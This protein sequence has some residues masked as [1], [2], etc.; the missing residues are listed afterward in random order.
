MS[1]SAGKVVL[2]TGASSGL[3]AATAE[4]CVAAGYRVAL[5]ARRVDR[6]EALAARLNRPDDVLLLPT[7]LR[8]PDSIREMVARA[9][10]RFGRIDALM[11]NAGVGH[12][13]P[14]VEATEEH[15]AEQM[16][17]NVL[18]V[19]R[20]VQAVLP[21]MLARKSGHILTVSSVAAEI[22]MSLVTVYAATKGAVS[23]FSEALRRE[24]APSGV[25]VTTIIP[26][27]IQSEMTARNRVPM[28]PASLVGN[29]VVQLLRR[30]RRV[31][32]V[33]RYYGLAIWGNRFAPWFVDQVGPRM[34]QVLERHRRE[35]S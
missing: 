3:G 5:A 30:P 33:P 32:V 21:G 7:D 11:A 4:A 8:N 6:L 34:M 17:V 35:E 18:G 27:F 31:A 19:L 16:D 29:Q 23:A 10:E 24:V 1:G 14:F 22:P 2:I 26:G 25:R 9:E 28:P 20:S 15:I 13:E 12:G